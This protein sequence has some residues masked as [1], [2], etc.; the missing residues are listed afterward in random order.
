MDLRFPPE[1]GFCLGYRLRILLPHRKAILEIEA[2]LFLRLLTL[3]L[4]P[5]RWDGPREGLAWPD[6]NRLRL[7]FPHTAVLEIEALVFIS[8]RL[9][10]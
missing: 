7:L 2:S 6:F 8:L 1:R 4:T 3:A 10:T 9:L 5:S